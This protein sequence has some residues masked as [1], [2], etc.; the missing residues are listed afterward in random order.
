MS[1]PVKKNDVFIS[2]SR[3]VTDFARQLTQHL[4]QHGIRF[5]VDQHID[6]TSQDWRDDIDSAIR[7]SYVLIL[8]LEENAAKSNYVTFE[9]AFAIG[10]EI[11]IFAIEKDFVDMELLHEKIRTLQREPFLESRERD[12]DK[13]CNKIK[14]QVE[15]AKLDEQQRLAAERKKIKDVLYNFYE[16]GTLDKTDLSAFVIEGL[17]ETEDKDELVEKYNNLNERLASK[18]SSSPDDQG[19]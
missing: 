4:T 9:W 15:K 1:H 6:P 18:S 10:A 2:Y 11:P 19:D 13:L 8:V 3:N 12:W 14:R 7:E 5:W 17:I 16:F